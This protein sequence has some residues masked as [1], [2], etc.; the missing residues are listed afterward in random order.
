VLKDLLLSLPSVRDHHAPDSSLYGFLKQAARREIEELFT[1]DATDAI[2]FDPFG[3]LVF[4][5]HNMGAVDSLNLFD[6]DELIIFSFYWANRNRYKR[7]VDIGANIGLHSILLSKCGYEVRSFEP[8]PEHFKILQRN[9]ELNDCSNVMPNNVAVSSEVGTKEFV[10]VLG[11]TTG[12]H[13]AGSKANPYGDL[14][15]VPVQVEAIDPLLRWADLIK[16]DAEG[17]EKE[18]LLATRSDHWA[19]TD[20]LVEIG[21]QNAGPVYEHFRSM[22]VPLY[23]QKKNWQL[24]ESVEEM[25]TSYKEGTL[26]ISGCQ[27]SPWSQ[28]ERFKS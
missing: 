20:A 7:V 25:P 8:D 12:S 15:R 24:V 26:F 3:R 16:L 4:P 27:H 10:R 2:E 5:Y 19:N 9:L 1:G 28:N 23:T 21:D 6:I 13:L 14:D 17:H 18:I 11:N 22:N